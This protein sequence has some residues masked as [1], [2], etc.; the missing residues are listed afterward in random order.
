MVIFLIIVSG[1]AYHEYGIFTDINYFSALNDIDEGKVQILTYG[2]P[3]AEKDQ[4]D[5]VALKYGFSYNQIEDC[6]VTQRFINQVD[7][8]NSAVSKYLSKINGPDWETRFENDVNQLYQPS[9][10]IN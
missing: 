3:I 5:S 6:I 9:Q 2:L 7:S 1:I 8:Y 4:I 10:S